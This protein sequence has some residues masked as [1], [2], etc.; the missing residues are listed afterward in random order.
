MTDSNEVNNAGGK[1]GPRLTRLLSDAL[2]YTRQKMGPHQAAVAQIVLRDFTNHVSDEVRGVMADMWE[3]FSQDEETPEE[4]RPLFQALATERGQAWA[5]IAGTATS[6]A[7]SSSV[8]DLFN[9]LLAPVV[10][11]FIQIDPNS[12]L[13][14]GALAQAIARGL[15]QDHDIHMPTEAAR[16]GLDEER[17]NVL[18]NLNKSI[19]TPPELQAMFNRGKLT[20]GEIHDALMRQ[21]F[22]G[23]WRNRLIDLAHADIG[24]PDISAMWNRSVVNTDEAIK[25]GA[26]IGYDETQVRR[27]LELGGEPLSPMQLGEAF[28]RGFIDSKRFQRGIIQGP[29]RSEWFDVLEKLQ[30]ARMS[31]IDAASAVTQG[32]LS[33][34]EGRRIASD[35]GLEPDDFSTLIEIA[36]RPPGVEFA[37]EALNR[38]FI[39]EPEF[40]T[41]FLESAIKNRYLPLL[42]K[43]RTRLM[44]QET[45]R[46]AYREGVYSRE[47]TLETLQQHGFT[48]EDAA[49][50]VSLEDSRRDETTKE[51]TRAQI[52]DL[53][54]EQVISRETAVSFLIDLGYNEAN[55]E[56]M[57]ALAEIKRMQRF[58]NAAITRVRS[59]YLG[60]RID[61]VEASSQLDRLGVPPDQRDNLLALWDID[62]TTITK[63]LTPAQ[64]RQALKRD[65]ISTEDALVRLKAQGYDDTDAV[66][67]LQLTA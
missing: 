49:T 1:V 55:V 32:H 44:P 7:L 11:N 58:V 18:V 65:M 2:V 42:L 28:R 16:G 30:F 53:Y 27:A 45:A 21:G 48:A 35:N 25:L 37:Q 23:H 9:N 64:I 46:L 12:L 38:G 33:D 54:D 67:F 22:E 15:Y 29:T 8:A 40:R 52:V 34:A 13:P 47:K 14:A 4:L 19:P 50:L 36:G 6:T 51:L 20:Y 43:M 17:L 59:A 31:T 39:G 10:Q 57:M 66:L 5:W 60:G 24:L 63:T 41:M 3:K 61:D 62:R 26:R 56:L